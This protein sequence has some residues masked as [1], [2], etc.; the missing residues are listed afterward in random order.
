MIEYDPSVI[1]GFA[2]E[3]YHRANTVVMVNTAIF[4]LVGVLIGGVVKGTGVAIIVGLV[5]AGIGYYWGII[6]DYK[7][8][9]C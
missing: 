4:G 8:H 3:L 1:H 7:K 9:F 2:D 5:A 6:G